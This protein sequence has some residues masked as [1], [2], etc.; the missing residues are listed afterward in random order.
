MIGNA[1]SLSAVG[2]EK[3]FYVYSSCSSELV[4]DIVL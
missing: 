1:G 3:K 2:Q 4:V